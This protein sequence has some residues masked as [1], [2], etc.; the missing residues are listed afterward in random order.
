VAAFWELTPRET[1]MT[2]EAAI[3]RRRQERERDL[4]LAWHMAALQ[5]AKRLPTLKRLLSG[6]TP[7]RRLSAADEAARREEFADLTQRMGER[8]D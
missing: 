2:I 8:H 1:L 6:M 7:A 3:W 5:R 4:W